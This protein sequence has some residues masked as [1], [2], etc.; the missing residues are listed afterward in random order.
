MP[1]LELVLP[2]YNEARSLPR[3][4][5]RARSAALAAGFNATTFQLILVEN[6]SK[7]DSARVLA[8][9]GQ[10]ELQDWFRVVR[11]PVNQGYGY[12]LTRGLAATRAPV[13]AWSHA[14]Q[15]CDP[16]DVFVAY[17]RLR[18]L[19]TEK[20]LVKGRRLQRHWRD[21]VVSRV[22]EGCA[23][24]TLGIVCSEVNAQPKVFPRALLVSLTNPPKGFAFDL[25]VLYQ[26]AK[27]G[28]RVDTIPVLFPPRVHGLSNWAG[29]FVGRY[30]TILGMLRYMA[31]L[32]LSEGRV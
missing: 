20:V 28:Y 27:R 24:V 16:A 7:D 13:V 25:Y 18:D 26:A 1:E 23:R 12:G 31:M 2:C 22:F 15:Q 32:S 19:G 5:E 11:V 10:G 29:T 3:L 14:D 9:L 21:V 4:V 6:G 8:E 17:R 30:R